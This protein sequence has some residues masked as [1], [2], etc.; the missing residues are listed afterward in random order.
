[1]WVTEV[2]R[3]ALQTKS[4]LPQAKMD[5]PQAKEAGEIQPGQTQA[6]GELRP[7]IF[8]FDALVWRTGC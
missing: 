5:L 3:I 7:K 8:H 4:N 2:N 6:R 1:L